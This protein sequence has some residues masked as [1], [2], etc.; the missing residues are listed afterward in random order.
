[1][2]FQNNKHKK[3]VLSCNRFKQSKQQTLL[4][5]ETQNK[6]FRVRSEITPAS[7]HI[8]IIE[9]LAY[10]IHNTEEAGEKL[11]EKQRKREKP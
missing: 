4:I 2:K 5:T 6:N 7:K 1:M 8:E 3:A 10:E 9:S 11:E